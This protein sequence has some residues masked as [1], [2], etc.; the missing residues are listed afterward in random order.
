VELSDDTLES[1]AMP[2]SWGRENAL[3]GTVA[4]GVNT[5]YLRGLVWLTVAIPV[6][7]FDSFTGEVIGR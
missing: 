5:R 7:P 1:I 6:K 2:D 3:D 4:G